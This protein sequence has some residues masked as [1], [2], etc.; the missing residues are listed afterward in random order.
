MGNEQPLLTEPNKSTCERHVTR[1]PGAQL[2]SDM[3]EECAGDSEYNLV[4]PSE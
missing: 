1:F 4:G 3:Y 2:Q